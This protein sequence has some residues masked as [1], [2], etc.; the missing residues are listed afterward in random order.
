MSRDR[1][2]AHW[3]P[4]TDAEKAAVWQQVEHILEDPSFNR[5]SRYPSLLRFIVSRFLDGQAETLK[6]RILGI[7]VFGRKPDYDTTQDPI[8]RVTAA[9][10]RKRILRYYEESDHS[11]ELHISIPS[12]SYVPQLEPPADWVPASIGDGAAPATEQQDAAEDVNCQFIR[13][14]HIDAED[15]AGYGIVRLILN[16]K[17]LAIILASAMVLSA[18]FLTWYAHRQSAYDAFWAPL[19]HPSAPILICMADHNSSKPGLMDAANPQPTKDPMEQR[20]FTN[21]SNVLQ[22]V[23]LTGMISGHTHTYKVQTEAQTSFSDLSNGPAI[24]L[25]T[26]NNYWTLKMTAQLRFHFANDAAMQSLW[27][28][29]RQAPYRRDWMIDGNSPFLSGKD[30]LVVARFI[31]PDTR[32]TTLVVAGLGHPSMIEGVRFILSPQRLS[33]VDKLAPLGWR[34]RNLELVMESEVI[35]G[36]AGPLKIDAVYV[37]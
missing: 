32:Q 36:T 4:A 11:N 5:S 34:N 3:T 13:K 10:I 22:L 28:A 31:S 37:W 30:Y 16:K 2:A 14:M 24:L 1:D 15:L 26:Y 7:E 33:E 20:L 21:S 17:R 35:N 23:D 9:E 6:E 25:G 19:F 29:D 18:V 27:I 8:V 12:G